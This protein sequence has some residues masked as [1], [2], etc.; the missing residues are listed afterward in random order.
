MFSTLFKSKKPRTHVIEPETYLCFLGHP[1]TDELIELLKN[2]QWSELESRLASYSEDALYP[3]LLGLSQ[4]ILGWKKSEWPAIPEQGRLTILKAYFLAGKAWIERTGQ[5][6]SEVTEDQF[7][8][9]YRV[10]DQAEDLLSR[11]FDQYPQESLAYRAMFKVYM[12]QSY[13]TDELYQ[14]FIRYAKNSQQHIACHTAMAYALTKQ[15]GGSH[16]DLFSFCRIS[17]KQDPRFAPMVAYAHYMRWFYDCYF[18]D[19]ELDETYFLRADVAEELANAF[20]H[21]ETLEIPEYERRIGANYFAFC[22]SKTSNA[23]ML[24]RALMNVDRYP[25]EDVWDS[26]YNDVFRTINTLR[27]YCGLAKFK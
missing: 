2:D 9:F 25:L 12:G 18:E 8:R 6:A 21:Y 4:V 3:A 20:K 14:V 5:R 26:E 17:Y 19:G 22:F 16:K 13:G 24:K 10:L 27:N 11:Y 23:A 7:R 15:W 1:H